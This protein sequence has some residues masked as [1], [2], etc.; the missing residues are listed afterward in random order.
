MKKKRRDKRKGPSALHWDDVYLRF[1]YVCLCAGTRTAPACFAQPRQAE[2]S[3]RIKYVDCLWSTGR[4]RQFLCRGN[5]KKTCRREEEVCCSGWKVNWSYCT[6]CP[7]L[8]LLRRSGTPSTALHALPGGPR[9]D[10][11]IYIFGCI[12]SPEV[13]K[14]KVFPSSALLENRA[15]KPKLTTIS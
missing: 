7:C 2:F 3:L 11:L 12:F 13:L 10:V 4:I 14:H 6:L 5:S 9:T 15:W 1:V 8:R